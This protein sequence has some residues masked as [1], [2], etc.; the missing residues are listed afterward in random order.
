M[1]EK[2]LFFLS[3]IYIYIYIYTV[4]FNMFH[5]KCMFAGLLDIYFRL[6]L[7][8]SVLGIPFHFIAGI[9]SILPKQ[10]LGDLGRILQTYPCS[11]SFLGKVV[12]KSTSGLNFLRQNL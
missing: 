1:S 5:F 4:C 8:Y 6:D 9:C 10:Q 3:G 12:K 7:I 11:E 2:P